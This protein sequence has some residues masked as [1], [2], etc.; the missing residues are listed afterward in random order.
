MDTNVADYEET[1]AIVAE[2][3]A[4]FEGLPLEHLW[5]DLLEVRDDI[6]RVRIASVR[7]GVTSL[8][9]TFATSAVAATQQLLLSAACTVLQ[10]R[11][12]HPRLFRTQAL[13][14]LDAA[15]FQHTEHGSFV[16]K[17]SCAFDALDLGDEEVP[18]A[19]QTM[20]TLSQSLHE[21][22]GAIEA[23][24]LDEYVEG[25]RR[26]D[27]PIIS[28]NLCD[29]LTKLQDDDLR[30]SLEVGLTWSPLNPV[31]EE[32]RYAP[33]RIQN[34]YFPRIEEVRRA[35]RDA[36]A[37]IEDAFMGTV[38]QLNGDMD[39]HGHRFGE[40]MLA[41]LLPEGEVV[42]ATTNLTAEEYVI[43]DK[44]HMTEGTYVMIRG[45]LHQGRQP[46]LITNVTAFEILTVPE[47]RRLEEPREG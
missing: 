35:L 13:Q 32:M 15:Q 2:K 27:A 16:L 8:P 5:G 20:L 40:V 21:L 4:Y 31:R 6:L 19:R 38:E 28:S 17:V 25:A 42:R 23:D 44:A 22:V 18:F 34:D 7:E 47:N 26:D 41:L 36:G 9:L 29:A 39:E 30:N 45:R 46:R 24:L 14:F 37:P 12:H 11:V 1:I 33:L 43:A 3:L 10:P